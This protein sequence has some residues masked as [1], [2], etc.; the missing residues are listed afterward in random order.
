MITV[1][2][3]EPNSGKGKA[4]PGDG[5]PGFLGSETAPV[6]VFK[7]SREAASASLLSAPHPLHLLQLAHV[8]PTEEN[9]LLLFRCQQLKSC[10]EFM[11]VRAAAGQSLRA[12]SVEV[13]CGDGLSNCVSLSSSQTW[14]K[15]DTDHSGFI[16]T[17]ELKV[18]KDSPEFFL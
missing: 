17:E 13:L 4:D 3:Q 8:L 7:E 15:Y 10:E 18:S 5:S 14:R 16:E 6:S 12:Q 1:A 2:L 11:K 9:F